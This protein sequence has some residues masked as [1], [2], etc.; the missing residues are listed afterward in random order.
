MCY[1]DACSSTSATASHCCGC[2]TAMSLPAC[3]IASIRSTPHISQEPQVEVCRHAGP[4]DFTQ[5]HEREAW[6]NL[7]PLAPTPNHHSSRAAARKEGEL[8]SP[9]QVG[10][11]AAQ[12]VR[13]ASSPTVPWPRGGMITSRRR[14]PNR[15]SF[16]SQSWP[17]E[18]WRSGTE[19]PPKATLASAAPA[20]ATAAP[21]L[22]FS[23][24]TT[25]AGLCARN[26]RCF[27]FQF[28]SRA[29]ACCACC[30]CPQSIG[31]AYLEQDVRSI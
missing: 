22:S 11:T 29:G 24:T 15:E 9:P 27:Q 14:P 23:L 12:K 26:C 17:Q 28:L 6:V 10:C 5:Q 18:L 7:H 1:K 20:P 4:Q 8:R 30:R 19:G 21:L 13:Q 3:E 2:S 31:C 25:A 16:R